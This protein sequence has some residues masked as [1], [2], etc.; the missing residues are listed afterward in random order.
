MMKLSDLFDV[1]Y[2]NKLDLNK[3]RPSSLSRGGIHFVGRS[4]Q[5]H[6]V[7]A[8]VAPIKGVLPYEAG[9]ITV[10]LG[11]T[12]LLSSFVQQ[13]PFYTAQ[14]VAVLRPKGQMT[15]AEELY[16]CLCIRHNR[17]RYSAFGREANRT[18]RDLLVP[19]P[20]EFPT[21][22]QGRADSPDVLAAPASNGVV[23]KALATSRWKPFGLGRLFDLRKGRRLTKANMVPGTTPYVGA[24]DT[25]NGVTARIGQK[26]I[27]QGNTISLTY[28]G[29]VAEAFYQPVPYWATDDVNVLYPR[30]RLTPEIGLFLCTVIRME[31]FRFNYGRKWHLDRM[32]ESHIRLPATPAGEPDW[33]FM[34]HYVKTLP[35]SSQIRSG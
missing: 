1:F 28:N 13:A 33:E 9:L 4:S 8:I 30:F 24:S 2:G 6:G 29:S 18:L 17:L 3:M 11:G 20:T 14:N 10:A 23:P 22:A 12:K 5:N 19:G 34:A 31:K 26:P 27:H 16:I 25:S 32:R 35:Y 15:F 21:W 7:S